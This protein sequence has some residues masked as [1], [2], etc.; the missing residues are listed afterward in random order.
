MA[1]RFSVETDGITRTLALNKS[2]VTIGRSEDC[3]VPIDDPA[4]SR[5]HCQLESEAKGVFVR[6]LNSRNGTT[7]NGEVVTRSKLEPGD[8][9][10]IGKSTIT[11][12]P[13]GESTRSI[14]EGGAA[15]WTATLFGKK[16]PKRRKGSR[17]VDEASRLRRLLAINKEIAQELETERL[18]T[19]ILDNAVDLVGAERGFIVIIGNDEIT[20]PVARDFWRK[21]IPDPE[22]E[23]SLSVAHE[24]IRVG[25]PI[26]AADAATD[27]RFDAMTSVHNLQLRSVICVPL[28]AGGM[29]MGALYLDNR[30]NRGTFRNDEYDVLE[31]FADQAAISLRNSDRLSAS[32][33][34]GD[35]WKH[36][37]YQSRSELHGVR[38]QMQQLERSVGLRHSFKDIVGRCEPMQ[39]VLALVD[40]VA[41]SDLSIL[42]LG[43][44]GVGKELLSRVIHQ[45][46]SYSD[47]PFVPLNC[48]ALSSHQIERE[49]FGSLSTESGA[50]TGLLI[51]AEGGTL[52]LDQVGELADEVAAS[53][54]RFLESGEL[55]RTP[56]EPPR[57]IQV[58]VIASASEDLQDK[59]RSDEFRKDL[60]FRLKGVLVTLPPLRHR[61]EDIPILVQHLLDESDAGMQL[62]PGALKALVAYDWPGNIRELRNELARAARVADK[63]IRVEDLSPEIIAASGVDGMDGRGL[64]QHVEELERRLIRR[65]LM[66]H[67]GNKT[68][69]A[70]E[71]GL[72]RLGL[73][74]KMARL[75]IDSR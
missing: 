41:D 64:R 39:K 57:R 47:G 72:S 73:R 61:V 2:V 33:E 22:L 45:H 49:L 9:L 68:R 62:D 58:R 24:V 36:V 29:P 16:K 30:L 43:E 38:E 34:Q 27:E 66:V 1:I 74:K 69:V 21:D 18:L 60:F 52:F 50:D 37:A 7:R 56:S 44:S 70:E 48:A 23:V 71:L 17:S 32:R 51:S 15:S 13:V 54:L 10:V 35:R 12:L 65:A 11:L 6:D 3:T 55:R 5:S 46:S 75:D 20:V 19:V 67:N 25:E 42:I 59:A 4:L 53:L 28:I 8:Q 40:R 31:A 26:V 14:G 63:C